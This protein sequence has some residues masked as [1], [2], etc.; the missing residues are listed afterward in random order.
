MYELLFFLLGLIIGVLSG[1]TFICIYKIESILGNKP[2]EKNN[3]KNEKK[4]D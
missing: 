3:R 4:N 1:M 2:E